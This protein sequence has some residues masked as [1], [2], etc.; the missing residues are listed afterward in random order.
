MA[1]GNSNQHVNKVCKTGKQYRCTH[2]SYSADKKVSLN[3]HM[4]M[5]S[6]SP[7]TSVTNDSDS[8]AVAAVSQLQQQ[9]QQQLQQQQ[10][11]SQTID[12]YCQECDIRFSNLKTFRAHKMHYCSTRN[13]IKTTAAAA[14]NPLSPSA[15]SLDHSAVNSPPIPT[16]IPN[17]VSPPPPPFLALPTNPILIVPYSLIQAASILSTP[18]VPSMASQNA[19]YFLLPDG[20]LQLVTQTMQQPILSHNHVPTNVATSVLQ[21]TQPNQVQVIIIWSII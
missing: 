2:C 6:V 15:L 12:R 21:P 7:A 19:A 13:V 18:M 20:T 14:T 10:T 17:C 3:R 9:S 11:T 4:R 8:I 16:V 5:H 1:N